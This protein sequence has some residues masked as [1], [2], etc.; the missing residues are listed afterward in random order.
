LNFNHYIIFEKERLHIRFRG[1][2]SKKH[3]THKT[4]LAFSLPM[5]MD[6]NPFMMEQVAKYQ[7]NLSLKIQMLNTQTS[8][9]ME[10]HVLGTNARK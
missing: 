7:S 2:I 6:L 9:S 1:T 8:Q 5:R 10:Q 4:F 3:K